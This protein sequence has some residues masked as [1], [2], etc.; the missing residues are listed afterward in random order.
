MANRVTVVVLAEDDTSSIDETIA[1]VQTQTEPGDRILILAR[2]S[3]TTF[4]GED[5][6][7]NLT[8]HRTVK[9]YTAPIQSISELLS[10]LD[11]IDTDEWLW[12][13][14]QSSIPLPHALDRL[15]AVSGSSPSVAVVGPKLVSGEQGDHL[16]DF[17][18]T[19]TANFEAVPVT[20]RELDQGQ[21]D[22]L[23]DLLAVSL[24]GALIRRTVWEQVATGIRAG[25]G[26]D[27]ALDFGIRVRMA[28]HRV[29]AATEARVSYPSDGGQLINGSRIPYA[30][31]RAQQLRRKL[32]YS[33]GFGLLLS[34]IIL[35]PVTVVRALGWLLTRNP[36]H[37]FG[38][39]F[40]GIGI[41]GSLP[42]ILRTR[43]E[44]HS[45]AK[46]PF[47]STSPL[48]ATK[49]DARINSGQESSHSGEAEDRA[50][51]FYDGGV[52]VVLALAVI[53]L[54]AFGGLLAG[55]IY[56]GASSQFGSIEQL[57][58]DALGG[59]DESTFAVQPFSM[60]LAVLA[61]PTFW[62][63]E[64]VKTLLLL[65][66]LPLAGLSFWLLIRQVT[67][68]NVVRA[69]A[70]F[71][72]ALAPMFLTSLAEGRFAAVLAHL[73]LPWLLL[74]LRSSL[75]STTAA[76]GAGLLLAGYLAAAPMV[77]PFALMLAVVFGFYY[78]TKLPK[79]LII[80]APSL[81][82]I[83]P[84]V[85]EAYTQGTL[86]SFLS[87]YDSGYAFAPAN[88]WQLALGFPE[89]GIGGFAV[90]FS[91]TGYPYL[92]SGLILAV[93]FAPL[94]LSAIAAL[95]GRRISGVIRSLLIALIGYLG[96]VILGLVVL[97][98]TAGISLRIW[99]A[100]LLDL[101]WLGLVF[102]FVLG[103]SRSRVVILPALALLGSVLAVLPLLLSV[104]QGTS[105]LSARNTELPAIVQAEALDNPRVG[106]V[107]VTVDAEYYALELVRGRGERYP[108]VLMHYQEVGAEQREVF[109]TAMAGLLTGNG[110][111]AKELQNMG[112][113]YILLADPLGAPNGFAQEPAAPSEEQLS[114]TDRVAAALSSVVELSRIGDTEA[115]ALWQIIDTGEIPE[116][117]TASSQ[118]G[119][120]NWVQVVLILGS[121][122]LLIPSSRRAGNSYG[123]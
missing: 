103:F 84:A 72:W 118:P 68:N 35:L 32:V 85:I 122:L 119:L 5:S 14:D 112:I 43:S 54:A 120:L 102:A 94:G 110:S 74:T 24:T 30:V 89:A 109:Q 111:L 44:L 114:R 71:L 93:A 104:L 86:L 61:S 82:L 88:S 26:D 115:G 28:G 73:L 98:E 41:F 23:S 4:A 8:V 77:L 22:K 60:L 16:E 113:T 67:S 96:A 29:A 15:R 90:W 121:V 20:R 80:A 76:A 53:S 2:G 3:F 25:S 46:V 101:Y 87:G 116:P 64:A 38:E 69:A 19:V 91:F 70:S 123:R 36:E 48:W 10:Q 62:N 17:G 6:Y 1:A 63:P 21:W 34:L 11:S 81:A 47:E 27:A 42:K 13:L 95:L 7:R 108:Q 9:P 39:L 12:V 105:P 31:Q 50:S 106:T 117:Q 55:N 79:T 58:G 92:I 45:L 65:V 18:R 78:I 37:M 49:T 75:K 97:E 100:S 99:P 107:R 51:F 40:A 59:G 83:G 57:W 66:S 56:G 52:L 33:S